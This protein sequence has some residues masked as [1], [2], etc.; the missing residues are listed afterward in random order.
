M[1]IGEPDGGA[2]A[3]AVT[4]AD[5]VG[6]ALEMGLEYCCEGGVSSLR[7]LRMTGAISLHTGKSPGRGF[8]LA[9]VAINDDSTSCLLAV[10]LEA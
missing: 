1:E 5:A 7:L 3:G 6:V 4:T 10:W 9:V 2:E 8:Q